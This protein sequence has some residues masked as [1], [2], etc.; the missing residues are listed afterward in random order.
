M[1]D[2]FPKLGLHGPF[3]TEDAALDAADA[4]RA[5]FGVNLK[6]ACRAPGR[7]WVLYD[8]KELTSAI[9][10][11]LPGLDVRLIGEAPYA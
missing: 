1:M 3:P 2:L 6:I 9:F 5:D 11:H 10:G 4:I 8:A 7:Y